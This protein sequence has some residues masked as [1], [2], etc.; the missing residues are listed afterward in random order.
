MISVRSLYTFFFLLLGFYGFAQT[1]RIT[2]QVLTADG[3]PVE[4][5]A[6]KL[7]GRQVGAVTDEN[8]QYTLQKVKVGTYTLVASFI[9]LQTQEAEVQV[10]E[11]QTT[12]AS[13]T[14]RETLNQL[15]EVVVSGNA[16]RFAKRESD[17]VAKL[18]LSKME[19]PQVYSTISK[20]L[21]AEQLVF[22]VDDAT[23]NAPGLQKMWDA[24][25]RGGDGGSYYNLRGFVV[26]SQLRNGVAGNITSR[27]DAANL[28][29]IEVIKGPSATLFGSTLTSYGGLINRVTKKPYD[30][31]GGEI[32]Y[33]TGSYRF[34]RI[35]A[36]VNTPLDADKKVLFRLNTAYNYEGSFQD[37]GFSRNIVVAPSLS[38]QVND[39][40]SF[41]FDAEIS[42]GE[43]T[44]KPFIFF[45][46]PVS[47]LGASRA[48]QLGIDYNRS[49]SSNDLTQTS[50]NSNFFA[51]M[52][53]KLSDQ[54]TSQ[55]FFTS[56]RSFSNGH[57]PYYYVLPNAVAL[58]NPTLQGADYLVRADQSTA[59]SVAQV[60]EIQQNFIGDF[61]IGNVRNR[62]V[63][64][65]DYFTQNSNQ[66]F[67]YTEFDTTR[68]NGTIP[69]YSQFNKTRL[70][71]LYAR[72]N[73]SEFPYRYITQTY[74]A[75][76]SDVVNITDRL[77]VMLALRVDHFNNKGDFDQSTGTYNGAYEQT[78]L[79]P[80]FGLVYQPFKDRFSVFANY[81]SGFANKTGTDFEGKS[82]KPEYASQ[83]EGGIKLDAF[84]GRLN[85]TLSYYYI[86]VENLVRPNPTTPN[87]SIQDGTQ[88]S[89]GLEAEL[90]AN[91]FQGL[92]V[93]A[94]FAY[95][96]S[97]YTKSA[98]DV[99][100]RRPA[101]AMSPYSANLW[102]SYK[103]S[104]GAAQGL[105]FGFGGNY[106][107]DNKIVNSVAMGEFI[108]PAYTVL[109]ATA[110]YEYSKFRLGFKVDNLTNQQYWT[111]YTTMNPQRPRSVT[112]SISFKF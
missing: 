103:I 17:F 13:F 90:I 56:T 28:E 85:G 67:Y 77:M 57:N 65:L 86:T 33:S 46:F 14:L 16:N 95:N 107:S 44:S 69:Q 52:N 21:L 45:Y 24:T 106:A 15:K 89:Q 41:T 34:N 104:K 93:V 12:T 20:E 10:S 35:S 105:G 72:K 96:D 111:G 70:E 76:A 62:F 22:S 3:K 23:R 38:Y 7:K 59:N 2:G 25:G 100:G 43:G 58:N 98:S 97:K 40:L 32:T 83:A 68:K 91:P 53:Y 80:K 87:F 48:D 109:N 5:V 110:F 81:Q 50:R 30:K 19:N 112:G 8:G 49:Y 36:D 18:P 66:L 75:Y 51:Q 11:N 64:G 101:T 1:G 74:S 71:A 102:L 88:R 60:A 26:Q 84:G 79:S 6:I 92:N 54:W 27:I 94:G 61:R 55:T 108:L 29:S 9:G 42:S 63:G 47:Q 37:N 4:N 78:A 31:F 99:E 82:F 73:Y 39:R